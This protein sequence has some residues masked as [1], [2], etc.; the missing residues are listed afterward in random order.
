M[1]TA[2]K[3]T[4]LTYSPNWANA[5]KILECCAKKDRGA[6]EGEIMEYCESGQFAVRWGLKHLVKHKWL[7]QVREHER[8]S[9]RYFI[10]ED[11]P[12]DPDD[13]RY[14]L[15]Q[16]KAAC[17]SLGFKENQINDFLTEMQ[18]PAEIKPKPTAA[19]VVIEE[20]DFADV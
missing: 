18:N 19:P 8:A 13:G 14:T 12:D 20:D 5:E 11:K 15:E 9:F 1:K 3:F 17:V 4:G 2:P 10:N 7:V 16:I 6:K